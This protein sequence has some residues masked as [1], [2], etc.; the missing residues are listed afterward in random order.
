MLTVP[1]LARTSDAASVQQAACQV[2]LGGSPDRSSCTTCSRHRDEECERARYDLQTEHLFSYLAGAAGAGR[3]S[4]AAGPHHDGRCADTVD[5]QF[6]ARYSRTWRP[7]EKLLRALL[8]Q[9]PCSRR[10]SGWTPGVLN[11]N[12]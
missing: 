10:G 12:T 6:G 5:A 2:D 9:M 11:D 7:P 1:F 4:V 8:L 3:S